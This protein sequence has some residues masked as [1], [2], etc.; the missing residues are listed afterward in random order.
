[1]EQ[2]DTAVIAQQNYSFLVLV[3]SFYFIYCCFTCICGV[4][5][6]ENC[7]VK[8]FSAIILGPH[9]PPAPTAGSVV[10]PL[11]CIYFTLQPL[12]IIMY[13]VSIFNLHTSST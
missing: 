7:F 2:M 12:G 10:M 1:M 6:N 3:I 4:T 9:S 8:F 5:C 11:T 13:S